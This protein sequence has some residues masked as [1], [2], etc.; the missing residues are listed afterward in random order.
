MVVESVRAQRTICNL[1]FRVCFRPES[2]HIAAMSRDSSEK[3]ST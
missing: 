1:I 3:T 2:K